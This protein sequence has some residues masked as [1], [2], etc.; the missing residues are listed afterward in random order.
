MI[1]SNQKAFVRR[2]F[3]EH[4][5]YELEVG[6]VANMSPETLGRIMG[7]FE[8]REVAASKEE[9]LCNLSFG[10]TCDCKRLLR[11]LVSVCLAYA[12]YGRLQPDETRNETTPAYCR[13]KKGGAQ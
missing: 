7:S 1:N 6:E 8:F 12:I 10:A 9:L 13:N 3:V 4:V 11:G 5:R 2:E